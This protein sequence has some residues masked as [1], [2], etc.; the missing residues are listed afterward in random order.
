MQWPPEP[1]VNVTCAATELAQGDS[2]WNLCSR[3][4]LWGL[5][6]YSSR[7]IFSARPMQKPLLNPYAGRGP[8]VPLGAN[9]SVTFRCLGGKDER[10]LHRRRWRT[11]C[12]VSR[13]R[14]SRQPCLAGCQPGMAVTGRSPDMGTPLHCSC[15]RRANGGVGRPHGFG[16][17]N[18]KET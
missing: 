3:R 4:T 2:I 13:K 5:L 12:S 18:C 10:S 14:T 1:S 8:L 9:E 17:G 11:G 15:R 7:G 6:T 16:E